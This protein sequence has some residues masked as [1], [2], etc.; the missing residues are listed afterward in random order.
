[1]CSF[2]SSRRLAYYILIDQ[3]IQLSTFL[4]FCLGVACVVC[5]TNIFWLFVSVF[6]FCYV[7]CL[8][9]EVTC[10]IVIICQCFCLVFAF[11]LTAVAVNCPAD[12]F[13]QSNSAQWNNPTLINFPSPNSV[14]ISYTIIINQ[15]YLSH[16]VNNNNNSTIVLK[17][18]EGVFTKLYMSEFLIKLQLHSIMISL[19]FHVTELLTPVSF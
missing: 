1:M 10:P 11:C 7:F 2:F 17:E 19:L 16:L 6:V 14:Q 15:S 3:F 4:L 9:V 18:I 13:T 12:V 8:I 5:L